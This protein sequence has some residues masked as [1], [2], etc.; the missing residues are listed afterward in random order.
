M[1]A[2]KSRQLPCVTLSH[3]TESGDDRDTYYKYKVKRVD[4]VGTSR[5]K[6]EIN[7]GCTKILL[8]PLT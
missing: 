7:Y 5:L 1:D 2:S 4:L 6:G 8:Y 3:S